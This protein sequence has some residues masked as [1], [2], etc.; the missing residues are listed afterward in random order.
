M[1]RV[2]RMIVVL[3]S[4]AVLLVS[5]IH[6]AGDSAVTRAVK[7]GDMAAVRKLINTHADVNELSGDASTPLLWAVHKSDLEMAR[8]LLSA[9]AKPDVPNNYGV[10]PLLE[11]SRS[12]D[13]EM[14]DV[15][16]KAGADPRRAH[17]DGETTLMAASRAGSVP[18]VR[19]LLEHGVDINATDSFQHETALMWASAEGHVDVVSTGS[20]RSRHEP[21]EWRRR[22]CSHDRYL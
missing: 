3:L 20:G 8:L 7:S 11:A 21:E 10:T 17:T 2:A 13:V 4:V 19:L 12:G 22:F 9:G 1:V 18:A 14:M 5:A 6:G 16:V 15:L